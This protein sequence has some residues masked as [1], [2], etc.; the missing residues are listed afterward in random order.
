[1][2]V[3]LGPS[4]FN[5]LAFNVLARWTLFLCALFSF[6]LASAVSAADPIKLK[7]SFFSSDRELAYVAL[8]KPFV[9]AVNAEAKGVIEIEPYTGGKLGSQLA[10]QAQM[11]RDGVADIAF[12]SPNLTADK[13]PDD[14]VMQIPGLFK[15]TRE[16][17]ITYTRLAISGALDGYGDFLVLGA[18]GNLPAVINSRPPI[19]SLEDLKGKRVRVTST[20]EGLVL[21]TFGM[22]PMQMPINEVSSAIS[23][24]AMDA[25]TVS[26]GPLFEFGISRVTTY[27]YFAPLGAVPLT[28][29]MNRRAF[30]GLPAA[31]Q[32]A[33][34]KYS[35]DWLAKR[36]ADAYEPYNLASEERLKSD[37]ARRVVIPI[38]SD[39]DAFHAAS[40]RVTE[41]WLEQRPHNRVVFDR[42][43]TE[44][45]KVRS[46]Y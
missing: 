35:G 12:A 15:N 14:A 32:D 41:K 23:S 26:P 8:I 17:T 18:I 44:L 40:E 10:Q 2:I 24:G 3:K 25:C 4:M 36:Y 6:A 13:F 34:R 19:A 16:A 5:V 1:M 20:I 22:I 43:Q 9:D 11:V 31:A 29:L 28:L 33:I 27:H 42:L 30:D 45:A 7:L 37:P 21:Q 46:A 39:L 38:Q